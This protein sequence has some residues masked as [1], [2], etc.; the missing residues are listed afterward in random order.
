MPLYAA[1]SLGVPS[2]TAR[3]SSPHRAASAITFEPRLPV[4]PVNRMR[5]GS[6]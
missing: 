3:T 2:S 4:A 1:K 5:S 6:D